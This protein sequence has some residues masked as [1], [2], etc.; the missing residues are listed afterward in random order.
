MWTPTLFSLTAG[1][2][3][4]RFP[5]S[6]QHTWFSA[7]YR[8]LLPWPSSSFSLDIPS[9]DFTVSLFNLDPKMKHF[10][11]AS[12]SDPIFLCPSCLL[13]RSRKTHLRI[14]QESIFSFIGLP[15]TAAED[16]PFLCIASTTNLWFIMSII[17]LTLPRNHIYYQRTLLLQHGEAELY[18]SPFLGSGPSPAQTQSY[19][20][21]HHLSAE[22]TLHGH[23]WALSGGTATPQIWLAATCQ[24]CHLGKFLHSKV[25]I[26][27]V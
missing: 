24:L 19:R 2:N 20:A 14:N 25:S 17:T 3:F 13:P 5:S 22:P 21:Q 7:L 1:S 9:Y 16:D 8:H 11:P 15:D 27:H 18:H 4:S 12:P 23:E 26:F 6:S 10:W